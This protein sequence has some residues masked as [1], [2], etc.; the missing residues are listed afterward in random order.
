MQNLI[1]P[2]HVK[3]GRDMRSIVRHDIGR[4]L[5][6]DQAVGS[7]ARFLEIDPESV[8]LAIAIANEADESDA[9]NRPALWESG[10]AS[11][12]RPGQ[13]YA[14]RQRRIERETARIWEV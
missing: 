8:R 1:T 7:L 12:V 4:G 6:F 14:S 13:P 11:A 5:S 3:R 9:E 2:T 10:A